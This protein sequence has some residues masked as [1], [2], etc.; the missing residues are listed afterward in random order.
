MS[1]PQNVVFGYVIQVLEK[2]NIPYMIGGSVAAIVYGEPRLTLDM[3]VV[4]DLKETQAKDFVGQFGPEYYVNFES[5]I[6]AI[7]NKG[8]FNIIQ[9]EEGL[10]V[11]FYVLPDDEFS[12][13]EFSRRREEAFDATRRAVFVSPEDIIL[14]KLEW[15]KMGQSQKHL[16]DIRGILAV[17]AAKLDISYIDSW[18]QKLGIVDLWQDLKKKL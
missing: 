16:D 10:K 12:K 17:S 9:S 1:N 14:K 3:D 13:S 7:K 18:S 6:E 5:I 11:D 4:I 15:Y 2:L 8:H